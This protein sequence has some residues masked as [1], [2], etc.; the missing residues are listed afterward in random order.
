MPHFFHKLQ[1][2]YY[3]LFGIC[4][5][6]FS[7]NLRHRS[8][9]AFHF[10]PRFD[11]N[12]VVRNTQTMEKWGSEERSGGMPFHKGQNVQ[13]H[14]DFIYKICIFVCIGG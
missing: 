1:Y 6:R 3:I 2:F 4:T 12:V 8:G 11:E 7:I 10:N 9:I 5:T 14:N 13:V